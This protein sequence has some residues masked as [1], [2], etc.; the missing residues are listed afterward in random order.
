MDDPNKIVSQYMY[1]K[2][3]FSKWMGIQIEEVK[4]GYCRLSMIVRTEMLNGF[5]IAHG[6]ITYSLADSCFAFATN[7]FGK[8]AVSIETS[9]SHT[10]GVFEGDKL[11]AESRQLKEGNQFSI[12]EIEVKN[13]NDKIVALFKGTVYKSGE[14][15]Q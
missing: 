9:I 3:A 4:K 5:K 10:R 6:G 14:T 12:Y 2:D 15:W 1:D 13:Q 11:T 7:S 8:K